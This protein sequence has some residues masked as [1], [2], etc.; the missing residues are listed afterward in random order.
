VGQSFLQTLDPQTGKLTFMEK[1][2]MKKQNLHRWLF[3]IAGL[4]MLAGLLMTTLLFKQANINRYPSLIAEAYQETR[5][6]LRVPGD[7]EVKL[8]RTGAYGIYF[9]YDLTSSI[10]PEVE[11][12]PTIDCTLTSKTT[13]AVIEAVPD[14]VQTNRYRSKDLH[15]GVLIMSLT[16]EKPGAY[17]FACDYQDG[18]VEPEI[19]VALGPNYFWEFLRVV[20]KSG[21]PVL[22]GSSILCGSVLLAFLLL[23]SGVVFKVRNR[24]Q[25]GTHQ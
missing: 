5:H 18:R 14:Y 3:S 20:W 10:Y 12:P 23:I 24:T 19:R 8:N 25:F 7:M 22:G 21:L 4:I 15:S 11:I 17:T 6:H 9:E 13:G 16:V 1:N 2:K